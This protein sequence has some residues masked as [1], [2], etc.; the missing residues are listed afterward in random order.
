MKKKVL[1][2]L[3]TGVFLVGM[4]GVAQATPALQL[5]IL[6]GTYDNSTE[7]IVSNGNI[8]TLYAYLNPDND[9][10]LADVYR[11]SAA[12]TPSTDVA[13][14]YGSFVF[15]GTTIAVTSDITYGTPP[16]DALFDDI[17]G[18]G[19]FETYYKE[20]SFT[21]NPLNM[22]LLAN[23][24][25]DAGVGPITSIPPGTPEKDIMYY[26][27]FDIDTSLL[28]AG[29]VIHFDLYNQYLLTEKGNTQFAPFSHDAESGPGQP[30]P[31]P[32]TMLL[33][34]TGLAGLVAARRRRK[35]AMQ[36]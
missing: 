35:A 15:G 32:A 7:T 3:A 17:P 1:A 21:F 31:E 29:S 2:A 30:I 26:A 16:L 5:D 24:K 8:F 34:G 10:D 22:A 12:L 18:H 27:S 20:F 19:I 9:N 23:S 6:N 14:D 13:G 25:D 36:S 28:A 4:T 11:I 33:L